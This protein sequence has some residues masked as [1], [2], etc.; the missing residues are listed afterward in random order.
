MGKSYI[1]ASKGGLFLLTEFHPFTDLIKDSGYDYFYKP[2]Y[3]K[4]QRE[5]TL[6]VDQN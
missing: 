2:E 3:I 6:M 5:H 4:I 1:K